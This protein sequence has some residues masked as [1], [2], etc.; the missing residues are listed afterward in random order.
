MSDEHLADDDGPRG[1]G[2]EPPPHGGLGSGDPVEYPP[3]ADVERDVRA[4]RTPT[5]GVSPFERSSREPYTGPITC[6]CCGRQQTFTTPREAHESHWDVAPYFTVS[7]ICDRCLS[8]LY[9]R[10]E[11][12]HRR[13][14]GE[15][16]P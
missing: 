15:D 1:L 16:T 4:T 12:R 9:L 3:A 14:A 10:G 8:S 6:R 7:P 5:A 2:S 13:G 11:C